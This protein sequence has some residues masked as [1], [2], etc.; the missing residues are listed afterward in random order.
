MSTRDTRCARVILAMAVGAKSWTEMGILYAFLFPTTVPSICTRPESSSGARTAAISRGILQ[1]PPS[2]EGEVL[3]DLDICDI[4]NTN[5]V[6][7]V[8]IP[9]FTN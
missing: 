4:V 9:W 8:W 1:L 7:V 3:S 2:P 5:R 6:P